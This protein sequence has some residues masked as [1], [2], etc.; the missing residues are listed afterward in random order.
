MNYPISEGDFKIYL[1]ELYYGRF[2][3][4]GPCEAYNI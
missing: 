3:D 4:S 2:L 1:T